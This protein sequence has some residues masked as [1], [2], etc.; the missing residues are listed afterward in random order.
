MRTEKVKIN[1]ERFK[2]LKE[3]FSYFEEYDKLGGRPEKRVPL[4]ITVPLRLKRRLEKEKN[5]SRFVEKAI[6][7]ALN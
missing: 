5:T 6:E 3:V 4:C 1:E 7:K 2:K